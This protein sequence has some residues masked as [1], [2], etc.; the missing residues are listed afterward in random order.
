MDIDL[1]FTDVPDLTGDFGGTPEITED[2]G[3]SPDTGG[4]IS[5]N[6]K[7]GKVVLTAKDI[8]AQEKLVSGVNIKTI[9]N[10]SLLGTGNIKIE[11]IEPEPQIYRGNT[12]PLDSNILVWIDTS[13]HSRNAM[14]T[15]DDKVFVTSDD[16]DFV[17]AG[18]I[19]LY[20]SD[21]KAFIDANNK[22]FMTA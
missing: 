18:Q 13:I 19:P 4:V 9:N 10:Q 20:T 7:T 15:A 2:L 16:L 12:E 6:G 5:V 17:P 3:I 8:D 21:N 22:T 14:L 1:N 11:G